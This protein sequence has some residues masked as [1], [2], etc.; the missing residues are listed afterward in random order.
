MIKDVTLGQYFPGES[1]VHKLDARVKILSLIVFIVAV[2]L[3][4]GAAS[5]G[6][7]AAFILS[8][9]AV[10]RISLKMILRSLRAIIII[11][12]FTA[13]LNLL[14]TPG[15]T[16]LS[17]WIIKISKEGIRIA[18]SMAVRI[19]LL[20]IASALLTY[21]TS[22]MSL[23][24]GMESLLSPLKKIKVPVHEFA[25][26]MTIALRFIPTLIDETNKIM[27]AQ[28]ARGADLESGNIFKR[29]KA[30]IPILVPLFVS[31]F[32]RADE[33]ATAMEC[34]L[35]HGGEGRTRLH[36]LRYG[37]RDILGML[38]VIIVCAAAIFLARYFGI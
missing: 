36:V 17:V 10:S 23:T 5:Y 15:E 24:D 38:A 21:T 22:P 29:A 9:V 6:I 19:I 12:V 33:L 4:K 16:V 18:V 35:Y 8:C 2:F 32:R 27:A 14:Y 34:R 11:V 1:F 7:C 25:M 13:L 30:L 20:V 3:C 26:M 28:K 37:K 31:S